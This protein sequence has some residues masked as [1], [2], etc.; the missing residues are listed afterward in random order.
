MVRRI[1]LEG[2]RWGLLTVQSRTTSTPAGKARWL[3]KCECGGTAVATGCDLRSGN[4]K[5]CRSAVH[6]AVRSETVSYASMHQRLVRDHGPASAYPCLDCGGEAKDWSYT[7]DDPDELV[8]DR[9][10][11]AGYAYSLDDKRYVP[12][13]RSCHT[14]FDAGAIAHG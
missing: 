8:S 6:Y 4:H 13:C 7:H 1:D 12:R 3:C 5:A 14:K 11:S 10:S 9:G 2:T